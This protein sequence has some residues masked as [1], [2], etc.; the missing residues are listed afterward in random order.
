MQGCLVALAVVGVVGIMFV[1]GSGLLM[2]LAF[3]GVMSQG[4]AGLD[5]EFRFQ[6]ITIGGTRGG[7]KVACIPIE[8]TISGGGLPGMEATPAAV[9]A[10]QLAKASDDGKVSGVLLYVDSPGGGI[11]ASDVM[12][13]AV[14]R[15]RREQGKPV[16]ACLMDVAASGGYYVSVAADRIIAHPTTITGSI[17]VMMPLYDASGLMSK[18]GIQDESMATGPFK[19]VGSPLKAKDEQEKAAERELLEG[20]LTEMHERFVSVVAEGRGMEPKQVRELADG[21]IF[22]GPQALAH[23]L[24]DEIGY[25]SD[26]VAAVEKLA[27]V[28]EVHL[29]RYR[30]VV[31][32]SEIFSVY[33]QGPSLTLDLAHGVGAHET[34]PLFM[35]VPPVPRQG[36]AGAN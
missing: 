21:R 9:F 36:A 1:L 15:F 29:V 14:V 34:R 5:D 33:S 30:R 13:Q 26:A 10:A 11:T 22:T 8:G 19:D 35:W 32:L 4:T 31:P 17:G 18:I 2:L 28:R 25:E 23:G 12:H 6:E 27:G 3:V 16:V 20:I 24:I 7:P